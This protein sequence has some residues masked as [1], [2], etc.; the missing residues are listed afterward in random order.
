MEMDVPGL[1]TIKD[2]GEMVSE[3]LNSKI[4]NNVLGL[5]I[6]GEEELLTTAVT[7][8]IDAGDDKIVHLR[9]T[10]LHGYPV[11]KNPVLLSEIRSVVCFKT[12]YDDPVY[13]KIRQ[14]RKLIFDS[15]VGRSTQAT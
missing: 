5:F 9:T 7:D 12:R 6:R 3:L 11:A 1:R 15:R 10:D 14:R 2:K 4:E 13:L 8:V